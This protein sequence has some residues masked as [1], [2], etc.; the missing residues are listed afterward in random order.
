MAKTIKSELYNPLTK[1]KL[2]TLVL[3]L[4]TRISTKHEMNTID[5]VINQLV[6]I[7]GSGFFSLHFIPIDGAVV[8]VAIKTS[9]FIRQNVVDPKGVGNFGVI[10]SFALVGIPI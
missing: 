5:F 3:K 2:Y 10:F 1:N 6:C 4:T 7:S 9:P 8:L